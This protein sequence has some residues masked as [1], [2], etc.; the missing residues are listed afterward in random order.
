MVKLC[1]LVDGE[2]MHLHQVYFVFIV[3]KTSKDHLDWTDQCFLVSSDQG[4]SDCDISGSGRSIVMVRTDQ[5]PKNQ[6]I[7]STS[8]QKSSNCNVYEKGTSQTVIVI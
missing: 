1:I 3:W 2:I 7:L 5:I 6:K 8:F 4:D